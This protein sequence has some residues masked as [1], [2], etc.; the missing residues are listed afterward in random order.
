MLFCAFGRRWEMEMD[1]WA[2]EVGKH[3]LCIVVSVCW[4]ILMVM[5]LC[6]SIFKLYFSL[7]Y[8]RTVKVSLSH[9]SPL[10]Q[11]IHG[12]SSQTVHN[13]LHLGSVSKTLMQTSLELR[14]TG[15]V[16]L[17]LR[18]KRCIHVSWSNSVLQTSKNHPQWTALPGPPHI[19]GGNAQLWKKGA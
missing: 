6:V 4:E 8:S 1:R 12:K 2:I 17:W 15:S 14:E 16:F 10:S 19:T 18:L 3:M 9:K 7:Q 5:L 11:P 13:N